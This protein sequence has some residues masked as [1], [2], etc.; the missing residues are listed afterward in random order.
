M[1][2]GHYVALSGMRTRLDELDRLAS[3]LANAGTAGYKAERTGHRDV[4]RPAFDQAFESAIDASLGAR[5]LDAR[6]GAIEPT[7]RDLDI[8]IE[9][10]GFLVVDTP[11]GARYTRNGHL[12]RTSDGTLVTAD[13]AVVRG[14]DGPITV[15]DGA[16][17][18][19]PDGSVMND[20]VAVGRLAVVQFRDPG[21]LVRETGAL[22]RGDETPLPVDAPTIRAGSLEQSNVSVVDR[23]AELT[24]VNRSFQALQRAVSVLMNDV[25]GRAIDTF[26]RR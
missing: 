13:G 9:G 21:A 15:G 26:G 22:L 24:S 10:G 18:I 11:A 7:G 25:D 2:G 23:V 6:P 12:S 17:S 4:P 8:A 16:I 19:D 5:R 14:A 1:A 3:D 20:G